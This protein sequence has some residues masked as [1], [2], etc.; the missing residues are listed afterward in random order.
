MHLNVQFFQNKKKT[1]AEDKQ[2]FW[3]KLICNFVVRFSVYIFWSFAL[4][5]NNL[6][7]HINSEN[8]FTQNNL[9]FG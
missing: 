3:L 7:P 5:L 9:N 4:R 1:P 2:E 6:K 8:I